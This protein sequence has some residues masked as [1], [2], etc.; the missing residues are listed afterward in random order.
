LSLGGL[1]ISEERWLPVKFYFIDLLVV[2][3]FTFEL[4]ERRLLKKF[5]CLSRTSSREA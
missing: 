1:Q 4:I 2:G 3:S 5:L